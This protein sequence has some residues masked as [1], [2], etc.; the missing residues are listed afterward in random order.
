MLAKDSECFKYMHDI[1]Y[2]IQLLIKV[3]E[4]EPKFKNLTMRQLFCLTNKMVDHQDLKYLE[5]YGTESE[6]VSIDMFDID[7]GDQ[8][9]MD[10]EENQSDM[11]HLN[12]SDSDYYEENAKNLG[13]MLGILT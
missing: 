7:T 13:V 10:I 9:L 2:G 12:E 4:Y 1:S 6:Y 11:E 8:I 5:S 3:L